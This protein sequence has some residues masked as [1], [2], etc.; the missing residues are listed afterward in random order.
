MRLP[1]DISNLLS[2]CIRNFIWYKDNIYSFFGECEVPKSILIQVRK[3]REEPT[4]KLVP[5]VLEELYKKGDEGFQIAKRM[6]TKIYYWKDIHSIP[7]ERK[8]DAINSLKELQK[9]YKTY[10]AQD[11]YLKEKEKQNYL[12]QYKEQKEKG[13]PFFPDIL[14]KDAV[15]ALIVLLIL[16]ALTIFVGVSLEEQADPTDTT[17]NPRPEWY[18]LFLFQLLKYFPGELEVI[19]VVVIP[20]IQPPQPPG[21]ASHNILN[22][23]SGA[24]SVH[25]SHHQTQPTVSVPA[26]RINMPRSNSL[27]IKAYRQSEPSGIPHRQ[28]LG[29][30]LSHLWGYKQL[31]P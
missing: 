26:Y 12:K 16:L 21:P 11:Q 31:P 25:T 28:R 3:R 10:I 27:I 5:F 22:I 14:F 18:F 7:P 29:L 2:V 23:T 9:A 4:L 30:V 1:Q 6:L 13:V 19:G 15:V 20:T 17:Y 8:D 24:G